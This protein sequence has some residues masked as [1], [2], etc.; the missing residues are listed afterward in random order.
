MLLHKCLDFKSSFAFH[1]TCK[2]KLPME[3]IVKRKPTNSIAYKIF[4]F[5]SSLIALTI[6]YSLRTSTLELSELLKKFTIS[7]STGKSN[8]FP[9]L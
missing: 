6:S 3:L 1:F 5:L 4:S 9:G 7:I 2:N 8:R